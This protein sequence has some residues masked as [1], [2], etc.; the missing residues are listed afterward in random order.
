[1]AMNR[2]TF[3]GTLAAVG[4]LSALGGSSL[5]AS[6]K[7]MAEKRVDF[8]GK[9][10]Q[11]IVPFSEGGGSD[12][13]AR[14]YSPYLSK[15]LPGNPQVIVRNIPGGGSIT[16][17][18]EFALRTQPDG[19][20]LLTSS[21]STQ[22]PYLLGDNRVRY[23]YRN[24]EPV[25]VLPDGGVCYI[26]ASLGIRDASE[27]KKIT[28]QELVYASQGPTSLDLVPLLAFKVLGLN[29]RHVFGMTGRNEGRLAFE[30]GEATIDYQT[31]AAYQRNVQSL[32]DIGD[33]V[34]LFSWG[35]LGANGEV[36]RDPTFPDIPHFL[37]AYQMM[38]GSKPTGVEYDT[39]KSF[40]IAGFAGA[41]PWVLQGGTPPEI[42]SAYR[43]AFIDIDKD[44]EFSEKKGAVIGEYE[45]ALG[46]DIDDLYRL[47]TT[48]DSDTEDWI[49]KHLSSNYNVDL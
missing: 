8:S 14:F 20:S 2:R 5:L 11:F 12:T 10:V 28:D 29:V 48:L 34:P 7:I 37:E 45:Q 6:T 42:V 15:Y 18:N 31:S 13:I 4:G 21:G 26:P 32:V 23:D 40:F 25:V 3:L 9:T 36:Q 35:V 49:K 41:K 1:M 27:L 16:G 46:E 22:F 17:A 33:A 39:Y 44:L 19:L 24:L 47:A 43:K 38:H 30:R